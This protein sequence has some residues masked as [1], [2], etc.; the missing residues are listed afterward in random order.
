MK[1]TTSAVVALIAIVVWLDAFS[2][3]VQSESEIEPTYVT[4]SEDIS[5][6]G[7]KQIQTELGIELDKKLGLQVQ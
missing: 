5:L 3:P 7:Q 1:R 4:P 6:W 2:V